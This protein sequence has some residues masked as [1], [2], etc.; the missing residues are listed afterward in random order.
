VNEIMFVDHIDG[1]P[2]DGELDVDGAAAIV[3]GKRLRASLLRLIVT[4]I[5]I[6]VL[7]FLDVVL[8]VAVLKTVLAYV[9]QPHS[10]ATLIALRRAF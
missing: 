1:L 5:A 10:V 7:F 2:L 6:D 9:F 3:C 8:P 4:I